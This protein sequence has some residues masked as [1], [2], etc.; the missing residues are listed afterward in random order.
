M[1]ARLA[2]LAS[3]RGSN[4]QAV[5]DAIADNTLQADI[6]GVFSDKPAA[7]ALQRVPEALRW[8]RTPSTY[9]GREAF[10]AALADAVAATRPDWVVCAGY[11]RILGSAFIDRFPGRIL[12]IHPSLLPKHKGLHTHLRALESGDHEHGASVHFVVAEL[13]AGAVIAQSRVEILP[14]DTADSLAARVLATEHP[15][16]LQA[17]RL[18]VAG[19]IR[20]HQ[21]LAL[22][23]GQP[24]FTPLPL[25]S[26]LS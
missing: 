11:M 10:D 19:R 26:P 5:L 9:G 21:G 4:L 1:T 3:G 6:V 12:N 22:L 15:L 24:L 25:Q 23:D 14:T 18:A 7:A 17:L 16:Y 20:L 8:A 13:D 2:I